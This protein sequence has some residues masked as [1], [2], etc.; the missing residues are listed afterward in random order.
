MRLLLSC[1]ALTLALTACGGTTEDVPLTCDGVLIGAGETNRLWD[2]SGVTL[3]RSV[4]EVAAPTLSGFLSFNA[5]GRYSV[6]AKGNVWIFPGAAGCGF[7]TT[8]G[9]FYKVEG[10]KVC[11]A[12]SEAD[13]AAFPCDG[14]GHDV[15][16]RPRSAGATFC[17][18][19]RNLELTSRTFIGL[20]AEAVLKLT[21]GQ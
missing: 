6:N 15:S 10:N 1:A 16:A 13:L 17:V 20:S 8:Y 12:E 4:C 18:S 11:F 2:F 19:G 9:G 5:N 14:S 3:D 21:Q 7:D